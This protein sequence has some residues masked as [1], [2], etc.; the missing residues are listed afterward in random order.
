MFAVLFKHC[1]VSQ[2]LC[3]LLIQ[4]HA[5]SFG[6]VCCYIKTLR[7]RATSATPSRHGL[8]LYFKQLLL[9]AIL[10]NSAQSSRHGLDLYWG[11]GAF[12]PF[13]F[14]RILLGSETCVNNILIF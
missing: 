8:D 11:E 9:G 4:T 3:V 1:F 6:L 12:G 7:G 5:F 10:V 14:K 2:L 13:Q